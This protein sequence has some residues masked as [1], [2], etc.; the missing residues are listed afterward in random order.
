MMAD[1][2]EAIHT[3]FNLTY[4]NYLVV[5]RSVLQSMPDE[6][7]QRFVGCLEEMGTA[8]GHLEWPPYEVLT[9]NREKER[10]SFEDCPTCDG[11]GKLLVG[12]LPVDPE[13]PCE[14]CDGE[15]EVEADRWETT[16][17]VGTRTDPIPHY[18]RGRTRLVPSSDRRSAQG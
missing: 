7:Q 3:W 6:W 15:G 10:V 12:G 1:E 14:D 13:Q 18:N 16:E 4:A 8:F 5:P 2:H 17:E 9:L 11:T